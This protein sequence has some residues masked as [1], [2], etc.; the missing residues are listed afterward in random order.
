VKFIFVDY[1]V[2]PCIVS[3]FDH[4]AK[5]SRDEKNFMLVVQ[6]LSSNIIK[7][8]K[9]SLNNIPY[10]LVVTNTMSIQY[11][12]FIDHFIK[13]EKVFFNYYSLTN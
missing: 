13:Q 3:G 9:D 11:K 12:S 4:I 2:W 8:M 6:T 1:V 5:R 10:T 7:L